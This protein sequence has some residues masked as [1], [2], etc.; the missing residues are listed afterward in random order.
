MIISICNNCI[1]RRT[2]IID[3]ALRDIVKFDRFSERAE[4]VLE[5]SIRAH[6][7]ERTEVTLNGYRFHASTS[8]LVI[9]IVAI[10]WNIRCNILCLWTSTRSD[11]T[12]H[13]FELWYFFHA[14]LLLLSHRNR[15]SFHLRCIFLIQ[16]IKPFVNI[17]L[18]LHFRFLQQNR[19][20]FE[21]FVHFR[22]LRQNQRHIF[23]VC[24]FVSCN[25]IDDIFEIFCA[26][27]FLTTKSTEL[28]FDRIFV[29]CNKIDD[30]KWIVCACRFKSTEFTVF[31]IYGARF[32]SST[33]KSTNIW[34]FECSHCNQENNTVQLCI[35]DT[36]FG[37]FCDFT[38]RQR[39]LFVLFLR[40][41]STS[42]WPN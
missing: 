4:N 28:I 11:K 36:F 16:R 31:N 23:L 37:S 35:G 1:F 29:L 6:F 21:L 8:I 19:R 40:L 10:L 30:I 13:F 26:F 42:T 2:E 41:I 14:F 18:V 5:H 3:C 33:T 9:G 25:R 17:F 22:F 20:H 7:F 15:Y 38:L 27:W 39:N 24:I 32:V 34:I 12:V